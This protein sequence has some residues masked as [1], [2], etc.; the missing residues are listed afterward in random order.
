MYSLRCSILQ[1][2][3]HA[4]SKM[5]YTFI[6]AMCQELKRDVST[7]SWIEAVRCKVLVL[8]LT[9]VHV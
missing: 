9:D 8:L 1:R 4:A 7:Q 5:N 2:L 3:F 6:L